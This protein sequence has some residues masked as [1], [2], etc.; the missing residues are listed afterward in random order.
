VT[1][2]PLREA[3]ERLKAFSEAFGV[4]LEQAADALD[5]MVKEQH[6][7]EQLAR[8]RPDRLIVPGPIRKQ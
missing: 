3:L 8:K 6:Q 2:G 4:T 5:V 7:R 1:H